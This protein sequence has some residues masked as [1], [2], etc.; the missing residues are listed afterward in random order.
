M[1]RRLS[2]FHGPGFFYVLSQP[3]SRE[4]LGE[5]HEWYNREHGPL[6]MKLDFILN[7]Y[8]YRSIDAEPLLYLACYDLDRI[9]GLQ[10]RRYT[11]LR[12]HR[13]DREAELISNKLTK[14]DRRIY[15][16][17]S[18]RGY[19]G[20]PAPLIMT[21]AFVVENKHVDEVN[22][23]YEEVRSAQWILIVVLTRPGA[24]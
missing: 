12:E 5:Y 8:R 10:E 21:V 13:S 2:Q 1:A 7:G 3:K 18:S 4:V 9:S 17:I 20:G 16:D 14:L 22:R 24:H 6:R 19:A 23:W 15:A 11:A